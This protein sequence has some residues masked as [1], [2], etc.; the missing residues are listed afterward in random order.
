M[1]ALTLVVSVFA[2][3]PANAGSDSEDTA[4]LSLRE[5]AD[6]AGILI[7]SG[8]INPKFLEDPRF[9][10]IL[11]AQF[12]SL[13]PENELK[14][15]F[16]EPRRG[17]FDFKKLDRLV[18][19]AKKHDMAV[20]GHGLISGCCN[21][22]WLE[23]I[24]DPDELREVMFKHFNTLMDRYPTMDRWDVVT[25]PLSTFGGT[26]L[27]QDNYF[28]KV[29]GPDYVAE[30]F[31]I[32]HRADPKAK[33][34]INES[35]VESQPVKAQEFYDLVSNLV[36]E[37]VPVHGVGLETHMLG[38]PEPG[39]L[40]E[41]VKSFEDLGLE[42]AI[43]EMDAHV[44]DEPTHT[45]I[46]RDV[47]TEALA[48]GITDISFWN[49]TDKYGY[50][51]FEGDTDAWMYDEQY[52]PKPAY[53]EVWTA[54]A[55][56]AFESPEQALADIRKHVKALI[57]AGALAA[58]DGRALRQALRSVDDLQSAAGVVQGLVDSGALPAND[59]QELIY[60]INWLQSKLS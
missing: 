30:A 34:F 41:I 3:A 5:Q 22:D 13:S 1:I 39:V 28:Y 40:T 37:G 51:Y 31:R 57:D 26:G 9:A 23:E 47:L 33:L 10:E 16:S 7:G 20:K 50:G 38:L 21:P 2:G 43:T 52:D 25:E 54:L 6:R 45:Q 12:N 19:F 49:F 55:D 32:A 53:F 8:A 24:T 42:V 48:A 17:R 14:W 36:S 18:D 46:H 60:E 58:R 4:I 59:G 15:S 29:L 56:H 11:A 44:L 27:E 35:L